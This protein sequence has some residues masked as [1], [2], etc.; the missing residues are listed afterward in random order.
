MVIVA[1]LTV[2]DVG[3]ARLSRAKPNAKTAAS[4]EPKTASGSRVARHRKPCSHTALTAEANHMTR[5]VRP[6]IPVTETS[7][8]SGRTPY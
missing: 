7:C 8:I 6:Y 5:K 4:T 3:A 2:G 1:A